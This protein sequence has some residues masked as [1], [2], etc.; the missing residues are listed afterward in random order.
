MTNTLESALIAN[1]LTS[2]LFGANLMDF[3][4]GKTDGVFKAGADGSL[5]LTLPELLGFAGRGGIG[6]T[7]GSGYNLQRALMENFKR[8]GPMMVAQMVALPIAF[9]MGKKLLAKPVIRPA[10]RMLKA[11]NLSGSVRV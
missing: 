8:N 4:T 1:A 9:K 2:G 3:V 7:Y 5:R 6:G 11:V 10:N